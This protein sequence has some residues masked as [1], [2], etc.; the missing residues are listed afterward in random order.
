MAIMGF[1]GIS[2]EEFTPGAPIQGIGTNVAAFLGPTTTGPIGDPTR[3][4]SWDGF[5]QTF[6]EFPVDGRYLWYAVR[7]FFQ[8]GGT[9]CFISRVST[10]SY[11]SLVLDDQSAGPAHTILLKARAPGVSNPAV[12]VT[13]KG[14]RHLVKASTAHL[15]RPTATISNASGTALIVTDANEAARFRPG[16]PITWNGSTE[17][18]PV[19]VSRLEGQTIRLVDALE[20]TYNA[21]TVRLADLG[22]DATAFR[23][24]GGLGL[25]AGSV[26]VVD[27]ASGGA[28]P[29]VNLT[30]TVKG[31]L[32]ERVSPA[33]TTYRVELRAPLGT[34]IVLDPAA[35]AVTVESQEFSIA[36]K[37]GASAATTYDNLGMDP[38]HA[39]YFAKVLNADAGGAVTAASVFPPNTSAAPDNRP[40]DLAST[41]LAGGTDDDPNALNATHYQAALDRLREVR[42][43]NM[44][45]IP[46]SQDLQVQLGLIGHCESMGDRFAILD[47]IAGAPTFGTDSV[48]VQRNSLDSNNPP[49]GIAA[50]YYPWIVV[51]AASGTKTVTVPP[52]GHV[53]GIYARTDVTRGVH[54][55]PAGDEAVVN[56]ALAVSQ[57]MSDVD[58]GILNLHG[59]NVIRVFSA[60]GRPVVWGARTTSDDTSWQYVNIRRLF[61]YI[62]GSIEQ[63]IHWA[64]FEPNNLALW[65]KLRRTIGEFLTRVWEDGGLFGEKAEDAFYVRIDEALNPFSEQQLGRLHIEIG[66]R[67]SYPAEF[68]VVRIGIWPGGSEV[69]EG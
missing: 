49:K 39:R 68:I 59:V 14:D 26:I 27:Q 63:G 2:F 44:V 33:L 55:A 66:L 52:S 4:T 67:P 36:V 69:T 6:G 5:K 58:Q 62:E 16:D 24:E 20:G 51:G 61:L 65:Q 50:L 1:P 23:V 28:N 57:T 42:D 32:E 25:S 21:G 10:A 11:D 37:V 3:I 15:Y 13:V 34:A 38:E 29:A 46:D 9:V 48:D 56:A 7:G 22:A 19:V 41:Q 8:N 45:A 35:K 43:V 47:S 54:K 60:G 30:T 31:V 53:A 64:I 18:H 12:S 40:A 17:T